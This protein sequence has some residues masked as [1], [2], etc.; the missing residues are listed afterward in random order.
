VNN[1]FD[2]LPWLLASLSALLVGIASAASGAVVWDALERA[3]LAF[4]VFG[5]I[6][7]AVR[8]ALV[9]QSRD[10]SGDN[11]ETNKGA[12]DK[13]GEAEHTDGLPKDER[14]AP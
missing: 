12:T 4:L 3:G 9:G 8:L 10:A 2:S 7:A 1:V 14:R 13:S 6:G 11:R 5:V